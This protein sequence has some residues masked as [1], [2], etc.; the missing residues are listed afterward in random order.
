MQVF[1]NLTVIFSIQAH[2]SLFARI[3]LYLY[4]S[5]T[6]LRACWNTHTIRH[7]TAIELKESAAVDNTLYKLDTL[8]KSY[9]KYGNSFD[10]KRIFM[11]LKMFALSCSYG[12]ELSSQLD[13]VCLLFQ[14]GVNT[15][16]CTIYGLCMEWHLRK[17][18][19]TLQQQQQQLDVVPS[20]PSLYSIVTCHHYEFIAD[21]SRERF[22]LIGFICCDN[23]RY[24]VVVVGVSA[25]AEHIVVLCSVL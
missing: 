19:S 14:Y 22:I 2:E 18:Y 13:I 24:I 9:T 11:R 6:Q 10:G 12:N 21:L 5:N 7:T 20:S 4:T 25:C 8:I 1:I 23:N 17:S 3:H 16:N 15:L